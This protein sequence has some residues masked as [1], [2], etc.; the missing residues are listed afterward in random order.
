[1]I[2]FNEK[3]DD[4]SLTEFPYNHGHTAVGEYHYVNY[5]GYKGNWYDP[6]E[7]HQWRSQEGSW[8]I[9]SV[10]GKRYLRQNRGDYTKGHYTDVYPMLILRDKLYST[11]LYKMTL[12]MLDNNYCG[13]VFN[14]ISSRDYNA[15]VFKNDKLMIIKK[16][17]NVE[18]VL[19]SA[20]FKIDEYAYYS[21]KV[22]VNNNIK[23]YVD[24]VL[25]LEANADIKPGKSGII[26]K[27]PAMFTDVVLEMNDSEYNEHLLK[28]DEY[29]SY[30]KQKENKYVP[31]KLIKKLNIENGGTG[32]QIRFGLYDNK[33][34][35]V[36]AQ[37]QKMIL[38]D[39]FASISCLTAYDLEGRMLWQKGENNN[40]Y[41]TTVI[42]CD[43]PFQIADINGDGK[44][45]LIYAYDFYIIVCDAY[46]GDELYR[47]KTPLVDSLMKDRPYK[48]LN[49][50]ALRVADFKGVGYK[51]DFIIKDRYENVFAFDKDMKLLW[52]YH[53][54]NTGHFPYIYDFNNDGKDEMYV[55]YSMVSSNGDILWSLPIETDHTDEIIYTNLKDNEPKRLYLASGNEGFNVCN[56]DGSIYKH[57]EIGHAQRISIADYNN[58]GSDEVLVTSFWGSNNVVY[59]YDSNLELKAKRE[60][61]TNGITITPVSYDGVNMLAI[62]SGYEGLMDSELDIVVRFP[63]DGHPTLCAEGI[64]YDGDG[65]TEIILWDQ[66]NMYIYKSSKNTPIQVDEYPLNSMSNYRGEY[67][68]KL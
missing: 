14:Y 34:F 57:N 56:M 61:M 58:D 41:D 10:D 25:T 15:V 21:L 67:I 9:Q 17:Q 3:F 65:I 40:S 44:P 12:R 59:S 46:S 42:S 39:S 66:N 52:R 62:A 28:L 29:K 20:D 26:S 47:Y 64:D 36:L 11:Y 48:R 6:I 16:D 54:K 2:L 55:G 31:L 19:A 5:P 35:F 13:M 49:V 45:E 43:L 51:S 22:V 50:D 4:F 53:L 7:L 68:K 1:M 33:P 8:I 37:H 60:F 38:R 18:D 32:R 27:V 24:D 23:V 63:D 30:V